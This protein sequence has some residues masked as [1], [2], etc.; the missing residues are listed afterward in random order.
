MPKALHLSIIFVILVAIGFT[1]IMLI[2]RYDEKGEENMPF[3]ISKVS[4]ISSINAQDIADDK[5]LW[6]K[7]VGQ[8]NDVYIYI[9]KNKGYSKTETIEKIILDNFKI[10]KEPQKGQVVIYRPC[11]NEKELFEDTSIFMLS[12]REK[13][14]PII[15]VAELLQT[16]YEIVVTNPPYMGNSYLSEKM[17]KYLFDNYK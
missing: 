7:A 2:L 10:D 1:A 4:L 6:N 12:L 11:N 5:N 17:K 13:I 14:L 9:E 15:K 3:D 8:D 16:K